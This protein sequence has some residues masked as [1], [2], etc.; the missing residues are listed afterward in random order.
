M[1]TKKLFSAIVGSLLA[2]AAFMPIASASEENQETLVT[3]DRSVEIPGAVLPA[4]SYRF[5]LLDNMSDRNVV[6]IFSSDRTK[7]FATEITASSESA[8]STDRTTFEF[9]ER[10]SSRPEALVKWFYPGDTTGHEF[11]YAKGEEKEIAHDRQQTVTASPL[12]SQP[13]V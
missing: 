13:G 9:A 6:Q 2:F 11:L 8:T 4:G 12:V 10:E 5:V 1:N 3:F 7:L